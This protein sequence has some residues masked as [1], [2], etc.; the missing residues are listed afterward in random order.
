MKLSPVRVSPSFLA[1]DE[2]A[3]AL[4]LLRDRLDEPMIQELVGRIAWLA[5]PTILAG[6]GRR[7]YFRISSRISDVA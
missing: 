7:G 3:S 5:R 1:P 6:V 4:Q 2:A